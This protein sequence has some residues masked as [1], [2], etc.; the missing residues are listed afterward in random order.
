MLCVDGDVLKTDWLCHKGTDFIK[1][2]CLKMPNHKYNSCFFAQI[3]PLTLEPRPIG[4]D[5][6]GINLL[7]KISFD[8]S[9]QS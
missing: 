2:K 1:R 3:L 4:G 9:S 6:V 7:V 8:D 5:V